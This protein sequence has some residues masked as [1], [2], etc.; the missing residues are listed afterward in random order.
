M[1]RTV[2]ETENRFTSSDQALPRN[3]L[4]FGEKRAIQ[5][6]NMKKNQGLYGYI[7]SSLSLNWTVY[8]LCHKR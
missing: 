3:L 6:V 1:K 8:H 5:V 7:R 4:D 2:P